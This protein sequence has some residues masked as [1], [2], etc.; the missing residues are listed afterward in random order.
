MDA[1]SDIFSLGV[2]IHELVAGQQPFTGES[3]NDVIA[4]IL[5][6]EPAPLTGADPDLPLLLKARREYERMK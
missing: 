3:A 2:V 4:E 6:T 1:R 5:K